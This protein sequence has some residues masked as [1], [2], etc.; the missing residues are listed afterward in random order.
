MSVAAY[1][2]NVMTNANDFV[3]AVILLQIS[4]LIY[5]FP[6]SLLTSS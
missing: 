3:I 2:S 1:E 6:K 5:H 4:S